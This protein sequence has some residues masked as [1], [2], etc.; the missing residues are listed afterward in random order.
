MEK[1]FLTVAPFEC[2]WAQGVEIQKGSHRNCRLKIEVD[3]KTVVDEA[4]VG[5]CCSYAF[6][7]YWI[8]IYDGLISIGNGKHPF[9]NLVFRWL[10]TK[11]NCSVQYV[12]LNSWDKHVSYRN[13]NVMS[14]KQNQSF[15]WKQ[16]ISHDGNEGE[17][18]DKDEF[19]DR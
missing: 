6:Q 13:V 14:F 17:V 15:S 1:K 10:D 3:G 7:S 16:V 2:A 9:Q 11:P 19:E 18:D 4:G 12:E 5:L 8:S